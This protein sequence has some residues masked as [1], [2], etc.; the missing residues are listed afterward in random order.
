MPTGIEYKAPRGVDMD[1]D[2]LEISPEHAAYIKNMI[3]DSNENPSTG[4][5]GSNRGTFTL[6]ESTRPLL[7]QAAPAG[8]NFPIGDKYFPEVNETYLLIYNEQKNHFIY[9]I[10]GNTGAVR[11][12]VIDPT[13]DFPIDPLYFY[14]VGRIELQVISFFDPVTNREQKKKYLILT[15]GK[16]PVRFISVEDAI[17]T[18]GFSPAIPFFNSPFLQRLDLLNLGVRPPKSCINVSAIPNSE[19]DKNLENSLN[20]KAVQFRLKFY[21]VWGRESESGVMST[22]YY[23]TSSGCLQASTSMPRCLMLDIEAGPPTVERIR[24]E[25]RSFFGNLNDL[26][27]ATDWSEYEVFDKYDQSVPSRPWWEKPINPDILYNAATNRIQYKFCNNKGCK[28]IPPKESARVF[29]PIPI[30]SNATFAINKSIGLANNRK[31]YPPLSKQIL[32]GLKFNVIKPDKDKVCTP[33]GVNITVYAFLWSAIGAE[34]TFLRKDIPDGHVKGNVYY[35]ED[36]IELI[37]EFKQVLADNMEGFTG[38]FAGTSEYVVSKQVRYNRE[39]KE[40]EEVGL[41]LFQGLPGN[42]R[43]FY[44]KYYALQKFEFKNV[45]PGKRVFRIAN[46]Q[47]TAA[48]PD[49]QKTSTNVYGI[50]KLD[51]LGVITAHEFEYVI[52]ACDGD[53]DLLQTP[54]MICDFMPFQ[55]GN[56]RRIPNVISGHFFEDQVSKIPIEKARIDASKKAYH[57]PFT[58]HNGYFFAVNRDRDWLITLFGTKECKANTA[59]VQTR[60][61]LDNNEDRFIKEDVYQYKSEIE[62]KPGDRSLVKGRVTSCSGTG[63]SGVSVVVAGGAVITTDANGY[64]TL[65]VHDRGDGQATLTKLIYTQS[66]KCIMTLCGDG[67]KFCLGEKQVILP[68][69]TGVERSISVADVLVSILNSNSRGPQNGGRYELG[70]Y[71]FDWLGRTIGLE[72]LPV[73]FIDIPSIHET[74]VFGFSQIAYE[75]P[76]VVFPA[77]VTDI[78]IGISSNKNFSDFLTWY[79]DKVEKVDASGNVNKANPTQLKIYYRSLVEYNLQNNFNTNSTWQIIDQEKLRRG[80]RV[81][82]IVNGD[83]KFFDQR[84]TALVKHEKEGT[85]FMIDYTED[86][87]DLEDGAMIKLTRSRD[88]ANSSLF[89]EICKEIKLVNG[90]VPQELRT[91]ILNYWDSYMITRQIPVPFFDDKNEKIPGNTQVKTI[92]YP[93]EHHSPSDLWGDHLTSR[94]RMI[95]KDPFANVQVLS[96]EIGISK[97]LINDGKINGLSYFEE[98]DF[99]EFDKQTWASITHVHV[100]VGIMIIICEH[101]IY[102]VRFDED[103]VYVQDGRLV[104]KNAEQRFSRPDISLGDKS[105]GCQPG[106]INTIT[107]LN[108]LL[109]FVDA[110]QASWVVHNFQQ[111][112]DIAV[113]GFSSWLKDKIKDIQQFNLTGKGTRFLHSGFDPRN[114]KCLLTDFTIPEKRTTP[115]SIGSY[116]NNLREQ[117]VAVHE[118]AVV[119]PFN[120]I[121]NGFTSFTPERFAYCTGHLTDKQFYSFANG[122][123]HQHHYG[124]KERVTPLNFY[125][126]QCGWVYEVIC[127]VQPDISKFF[128]NTEVT[129]PQ[130]QP[131]IDRILT[132]SKQQS[133]VLLAHWDQ[134]NMIWTAD[135]KGDLN[136]RLDPFSQGA[137]SSNQIFEGNSLYGKWAKFRFVGA[138]KQDGTY[139]EFNGVIIFVNKLEKSGI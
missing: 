71:A 33:K 51:Q 17:A 82:F 22:P 117:N 136:K 31:K 63:V 29:N 76:D 74:Q 92:P 28:P 108:N 126:V 83:G 64:F 132:E 119:D 96:T 73:H 62:Y 103:A 5:E 93:F 59:L 53:V 10:E 99:I 65:V 32:E 120:K 100:L 90:K 86:L 50:S 9:R 25:V 127:N 61:T 129:C 11:M 121:F 43:E 23:N 138:P 6:W 131:F 3:R 110:S 47:E 52:D 123:L 54:M 40:I 55:E 106:Q 102:R 60:R 79:A 128:T 77:H 118:T 122:V 16:Q 7:N 81:E 21:D 39:T 34:H 48:N 89:F 114:E 36:R 98:D 133:R 14:T 42:L 13:L 124:P 18:N 37:A 20:Y 113:L 8:W 116:I 12:V 44:K 19:E 115:I 137:D 134:R 4:S 111:G 56:V 27:T 112:S 105:Y 130:Q 67:C 24:I 135:F 87:K 38:Y 66:G 107:V 15:N 125:G 1:S 72:N 91:G 97:A 30:T 80:D 26:S 45:V 101:K 104:A 69:C 85:Y 2:E 94:G 95:G 109:M 41:D 139:I 84:I 68:A 49:Y 58:D 57:P 35:G 70:I 46:H 78:T 88:C 75:L